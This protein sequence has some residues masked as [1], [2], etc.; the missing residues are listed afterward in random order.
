MIRLL[1]LTSRR[2]TRNL[3]SLLKRYNSTSSDNAAFHVVE[4][5]DDGEEKTKRSGRS[6]VG[7]GSQ[8][9]NVDLNFSFED[10]NEHMSVARH[11]KHF[12]PGA[13]RNSATF[14]RLLFPD[15]FVVG[16]TSSAITWWNIDVADDV[17]VKLYD[18]AGNMIELH[19]SMLTLP[20]I[21]FTLCSFALGLLVSFRLQSGNARYVQARKDWGAIIN[22]T[23]D[24]GSRFLTRLP[25]DNPVDKQYAVR[26]I[27]TFTV[28]LNY[29]LT[30]D[31]WNEEIFTLPDSVRVCVCVCVCV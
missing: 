16:L 31:G 9:R 5:E 22:V 12:T 25:A 21:P 10:W 27:Q 19:N 8:R 11:F 4:D 3:N 7:R 26:L 18:V 29:H 14:R 6:F 1:N 15:L 28:A 24:L 20:A 17:K 30:D 13:L 2:R 23:R